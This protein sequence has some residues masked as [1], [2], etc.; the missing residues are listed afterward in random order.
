MRICA[1]FTEEEAALEAHRAIVDAGVSPESIEVRSAYPL[2]EEVLPPHRSH[3]MHLRQL[4]RLFWVLGAFLGFTFIAYTQLIWPIHT[5]GHPLV[6]LPIDFILTYECGMLG[7]LISTGV[8]LFIETRRYRNLNPPPEEDIPVENGNIA[9]LVEGRDV[10][11]ARSILQAKGA[12]SIVTYAILFF[13][14]LPF[15]TGCT[16]KMRDQASIH[17]TGASPIPQ[18]AG[19]LSMPT[20]VEQTY[21]YVKPL[22]YFLPPEMRQINKKS[23]PPPP[24]AYKNLQNPIQPTPASIADGKVVYEHNCAFCHGEDAKG[25][26]PVGQVFAPI[27]PDLTEA[28]DGNQPQKDPTALTDGELFYYITMGPGTMP[29]F[30]NRLNTKERFD[31]INYL[32]TLQKKK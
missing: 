29:S 10:E 8:F 9:I 1:E 13:F 25:D 17:P 2:P 5:T 6:P 16:V 18:P 11:K 14:F 27:P 23:L 21:P 24:P 12:K 15:L 32:R 7:G 31:L 19:T 22:G 4:T 3:P 30:A 26:G 28:K 20:A